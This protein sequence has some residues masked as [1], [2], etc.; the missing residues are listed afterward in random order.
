MI[1]VDVGQCDRV[2]GRSGEVQVLLGLESAITVAQR[3]GSVRATTQ[4]QVRV[5]VGVQIGEREKSQRLRLRARKHWAGG[6]AATVVVE[7]NR[8]VVGE[9]AGIVIEDG[10]V[11]EL[12]SV[13][14]ADGEGE[15]LSGGGSSGNCARGCEHAFAIVKQDGNRARGGVRETGAACSHR[16][17]G[18]AVA[19]QIRRDQRHRAQGPD[20]V[21]YRRLKRSV[22]VAEQNRSV[23]S[24]GGIVGVA[25]IGHREVQI[26]ITV[27]ISHHYRGG[28]A[29]GGEI[30]FASQG[31]G[32]LAEQNAYRSRSRLRACHHNVR[33]L[34][35]IQIPQCQGL[36]CLRA[37][38]SERIC[39]SR[40][41]RE[42]RLR[43]KHADSGL[44][45]VVIVSDDVRYSV[46]IHV[47]GSDRDG[48]LPGGVEQGHVEFTITQARGDD[49]LLSIVIQREQ[50]E[51][52]V[53][54]GK[55]R[56]GSRDVA[57]DIIDWRRE[58]A[59]P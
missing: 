34:V 44:A 8:D 11:I 9:G 15:I 41:L 46:S 26:V 43:Q 3:V 51:G 47:P 57:G 49:H 39:Y 24:V 38:A 5:A 13:Q 25:A 23:A 58:G 20:V 6:E 37:R 35:A 40:L 36:G 28:K 32:L 1:A 48:A 30:V 33:D 12:V 19:V 29:A 18:H 56:Q 7:V 53:V 54:V 10:E 31:S 42:I 4:D 27:E 21:V 14:I 45:A 16:Q 17:I 55:G 2:G 22:A 59:V 50:L 52:S